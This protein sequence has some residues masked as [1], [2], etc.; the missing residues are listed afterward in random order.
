MCMGICRGAEATDMWAQTANCIRETA[1]EVLG[2]SFGSRSRH[3]GDW[4]WSDSVRSKVE[5]KKVAYLRYMDCSDEKE[6]SALRVEY[7]K[8]HKETKLDVTRAKNAAFERLYKDIEEKGGVNQLFRLAKVHGRKA[9]DLDHVRCVKGSDD[10][11]QRPF[12]SVR[13]LMEEYRARKKDLHMLLIDLE[14]AYDRVS[15]KVLWRCLESRGVPIAYT[16]AIKDMYG[17]SRTRVR[18]SG[19]RL[20]VILGRDGVAL[21]A[22]P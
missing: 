20:R 8:V 19:G 17:G 9:R 14:K 4:W 5:A 2:V 12:T 18:S 22:Y 15:R 10:Q 6:R 7:K 11:L 1:R 16:R 21:G 13:R 3:Q